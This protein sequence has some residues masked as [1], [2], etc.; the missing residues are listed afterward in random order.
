MTKKSLVLTF[1]KHKGSTVW[2][3]PPEYLRWLVYQ[4]PRTDYFRKL[5][6]EAR[7]ALDC[8]DDGDQQHDCNELRWDGN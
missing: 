3:C 6:E 2:Q 7:N 5:Q 4:K 1:G 8:Q